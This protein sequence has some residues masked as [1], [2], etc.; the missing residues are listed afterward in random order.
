MNIVLDTGDANCDFTLNTD[1]N[2]DENGRLPE[3]ASMLWLARQQGKEMEVQNACV[4]AYLNGDSNVPESDPFTKSM[5]QELDNTCSSLNALTFLVEMSSDDFLHIAMLIK[6][7]KDNEN[8][9]ITLGRNTMCGLFDQ[10]SGSGSLLEIQCDKDI[11]IPIK[12]I[13]ALR[14]D[15]TIKYD[16]GEV[17]GMCGSAWKDTLIGITEEEEKRNE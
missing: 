12:L 8:A 13:H 17:Y 11:E 1:P 7:A 16:V 10:W 6:N 5:M 14:I 9:S 15:G 4:S 2:K 3:K